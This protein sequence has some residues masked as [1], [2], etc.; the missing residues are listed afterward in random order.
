MK[1]AYA[2][3]ALASGGQVVSATLNGSSEVSEDGINK[4]PAA[5]SVGFYL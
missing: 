4:N 5:G 3:P 2:A 1:K